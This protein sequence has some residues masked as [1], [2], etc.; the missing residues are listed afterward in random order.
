MMKYNKQCKHRK[1]HK[2]CKQGKQG[3]FFVNPF[4]VFTQIATVLKIELTDLI[5]TYSQSVYA[6]TLFTGNRKHQ[7][8]II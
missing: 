5:R 8:G 3:M 2:H 4:T 7:E 1:Q 6:F